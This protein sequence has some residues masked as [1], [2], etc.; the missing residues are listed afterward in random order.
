MIT[1]K[2]VNEAQCSYEK[3]IQQFLVERG[4]KCNLNKLYPWTKWVEGRYMQAESMTQAYSW[5]GE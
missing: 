2:E 1:R 5:E 3:S 4:W